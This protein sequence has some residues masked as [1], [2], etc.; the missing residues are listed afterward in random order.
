MKIKHTLGTFELFVLNHDSVSYNT[1]QRTVS[2]V[3]IL[4]DFVLQFCLMKKQFS[5]DFEKVV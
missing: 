1:H 4:E 2:E 5:S 3:T